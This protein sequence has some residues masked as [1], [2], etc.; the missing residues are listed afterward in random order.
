MLLPPLL[1]FSLSPPIFQ[2][3]S[4]SVYPKT[5]GHIEPPS[6][7]VLFYGLEAQAAVAACNQEPSGNI[8]SVILERL[9]LLF[10]PLPS[11]VIHMQAE[12][13]ERARI[14]K[15]ESRFRKKKPRV[16]CSPSGRNPITWPE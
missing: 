5:V 6:S 10:L 2:V 14:K 12:E 15:R 3:P 8:N 9:F 16:T 1:H 4:I 13:I 7:F 11:T